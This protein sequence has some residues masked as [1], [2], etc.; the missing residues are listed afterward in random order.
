M[1]LIHGKLLAE[2]IQINLVMNTTIILKDE[3]PGLLHEQGGL[4]AEKKIRGED[5]L[6]LGQLPMRLL[7]IELE[8]EAIDDGV[9]VITVLHDPHQVLHEPARLVLGSAGALDDAALTE[10]HG[11]GEVAQEVGALVVMAWR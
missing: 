5:G 8:A 7:E 4:L 3:N 11:G 1:L 2:R 6:A 9:G 10:E